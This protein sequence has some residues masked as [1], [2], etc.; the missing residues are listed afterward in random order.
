MRSEKEIFQ[1]IL[2]IAQNDE[3]IRAVILNGSR[4]NP[5]AKR[6]IFQDYDIIYFVS[7]LE[8]FI[9][10]H[11]WIDVFGERLILQM[12]EQMNLPDYPENSR[13]SFAYLMIFA[14]KNRLDLTLFPVKKLDN[15]TPDSLTVL[16]LDKDNFFANLPPPNE[17]GYMIQK[18]IEKEFADV[19][20]EFWW[21]STYVAKGL[22]RGEITYAKD[23]LE[24]IVRKMFMKIIE[25]HIG[26]RTNFSVNFGKSGK[27]LQQLVDSKTYEKILATYPDAN[28]ENI[29][30]SFFLMTE[31]FDE[32][33]AEI[34]AHLGFNYDVTESLKVR[35]YLKEVKSSPQDS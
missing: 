7:E 13:N 2:N 21:V 9:A 23:M 8:S 15:F 18:P 28:P 17:S 22:W 5:N 16:L 31:I 27:N 30:K 24:T 4:A 20:N 1:L 29:W 33:S 11:S 35:N 26:I 32:T 6:D 14:D 10:N 12:P 19:C 34:A 3:R 25:W